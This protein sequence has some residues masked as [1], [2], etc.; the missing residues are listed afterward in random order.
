MTSHLHSD[1]VLE[2]ERL[3]MRQP[4]KD[5]WPAYC[6]F[7][8]TEAARFYRG[9]RNTLEAWKSFGTL[10]WH[11]ECFG[12]GPWALTKKGNDACIG[13]VG[14]KQ[15]PNQPDGDLMWIVFGEAEGKGYATEAAKAARA[16]AYDRLGWTG[17]VSFIEDANT[18]SIALAKRLGAKLDPDTYSPDQME[19]AW[20]H[21]GPRENL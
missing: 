3:I 18:R 13:I 8:E 10:R 21:P 11:W 17:I 7:M 9:F 4:R 6:A 1:T 12:F 2:T 5:D 19:Q 16:D 20:R 15:P 14:P